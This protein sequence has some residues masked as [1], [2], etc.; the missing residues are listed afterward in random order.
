MATLNPPFRAAN[1]N[2]LYQKVQ[3][4]LYDPIPGTY[5]KDL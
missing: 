5:S 1:M 3:R 4:G 2:G